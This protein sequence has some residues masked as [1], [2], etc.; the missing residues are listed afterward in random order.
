M[1]ASKEHCVPLTPNAVAL[2]NALPKTKGS[3][4]VFPAARGGMLSDMA[5]SACMKRINEAKVG[6]YIDP[7][8]GRPAVPHGMRSAFRDWVSEHTDYP[9][10]MAE[11]S[12]AHS[13]GSDVERAYRRGDQIKKRRAMMAD[14]GQFLK[15]GIEGQKW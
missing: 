7:R 12:L 3:D 6:G 13:V 4:F 11:I 2:L 15:I 8:S 14:W 5:L 10:D 1:K 9:R